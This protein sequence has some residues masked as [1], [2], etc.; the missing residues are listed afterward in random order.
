MI[1]SPIGVAKVLAGLHHPLRLETPHPLRGFSFGEEPIWRNVIHREGATYIKVHF[2]KFELAPGAK[3]VI[4]SPKSRN[5]F[6]YTGKRVLERGSFWTGYVFGD[7]AFIEV[8]SEVAEPDFGYVIDKYSA[9]CGG[10][11]R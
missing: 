10:P 8:F 9:G 7:I 11:C 1:C 6:T 4:S 2:E 3:V 5:S